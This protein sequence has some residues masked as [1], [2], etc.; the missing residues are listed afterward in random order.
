MTAE[1]VPEDE[2]S[3]DGRVAV[4]ERTLLAVSIIVMTGL[5][6]GNVISRNVLGVSWPFTE[7][8]GSLMLIL[9]TFGGLGYAARHRRHIAMSA[10]HD[11]LPVRRREA[12]E[13]VIAAV[14]AVTMLVMVYLG[15]RYVVQIY[16]SGDS[17]DVLGLPMFLPLSV[18]P[19]G[20]L[21]A[22]VRYVGD[23]RAL[24]SRRPERDEAS[25]RAATEGD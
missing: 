2:S 7:E 19:L 14:S 12:L 3:G 20:F 10:L 18:I 21:L 4:V 8:I 23:L 24:M 22:A 17:S 1:T 13:R 6:V 25:G 16:G 9:V 11:L 5:V 15:G